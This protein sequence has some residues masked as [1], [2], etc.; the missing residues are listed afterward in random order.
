MST[1]RLLIDA[2][3]TRLKWA[4]VADD[5]WLAHGSLDYSDLRAL[6]GEMVPGVKCLIASVTCAEHDNQL[7]ALLAARAITPRWLRAETQFMNIKNSYAIPEQLGVDRWMGMIAA[8]QRTL[9]A[10]LVVS[11]G[12]AMTV[13]ALSAEGVFLGGLI[14]PGRAL[15]QQSLRAGTAQIGALQGSW[16]AFPQTTANAV[17]S[18]I[19][20]AL[21]GAIAAQHAR[22]AAQSGDNPQCLLTGGD[23]SWLIPHLD[24]AVEYAPLLV[25]EGIDRV[26]KED[27]AE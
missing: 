13:D 19:I 3:N 8:R 22:L 15:M 26:A 6:S 2:G 14:I 10:T 20:A 4:R 25:L 7:A 21:G 1:Q 16:Q 23:A 12:T 27:L 17:Q 5:Q 24:L 11:V 18:G 9:T